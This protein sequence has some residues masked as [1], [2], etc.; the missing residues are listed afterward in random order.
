[1]PLSLLPAYIRHQST[2]LSSS[3][4]SAPY[5]GFDVDLQVLD[6]L[7]Y[8]AAALQAVYQPT[9]V[10]QK[11]NRYSDVLPSHPPWHAAT[12]LPSS[13]TTLRLSSHPSVPS[14]VLCR[15]RD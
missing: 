15:R 14:A 10:E 13:A 4:A 3:T 1:M 8:Q 5:D 7:G 9:A 2:P 11:K 12:P 6:T